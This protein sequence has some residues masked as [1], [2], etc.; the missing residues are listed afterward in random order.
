MYATA[1]K[2]TPV[3]KYENTTAFSETPTLRKKESSGATGK[4]RCL[5]RVEKYTARES[6]KLIP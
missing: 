1:A 5:P 2:T 3:A 6:K 4:R